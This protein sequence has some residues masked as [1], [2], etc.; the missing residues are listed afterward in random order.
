MPLAGQ[1]FFGNLPCDG[2]AQDRIST[3][4]N[5]YEAVFPTPLGDS[6]VTQF[7]ERQGSISQ[8]QEFIQR[9]KRFTTPQR[10]SILQ[11]TWETRTLRSTGS[12]QF[13][14]TVAFSLE[15]VPHHM[16]GTWRSSKK[17][18]QR[19]AA[20]RALGLLV[21]RWGEHLTVG[22]TDARKAMSEKAEGSIDNGMNEAQRL[23]KISNDLAGNL[24]TP[25]GTIAAAPVWVVQ[26]EANGHRAC[27][28]LYVLGVQHT[29]SGAVKDTPEAAC[30]DTAR[31]VLW[32]LQCPDFEDAFDVNPAAEQHMLQAPPATIWTKESFGE[33][34]SHPGDHEIIERTRQ[35]LQCMFGS[36]LGPGE[37][38]WEW[39]FENMDCPSRPTC[40]RASVQVQG[41]D[42]DFHGPWRHCQQR[43]LV[44]A[45]QNLNRFLDEK[46]FSSPSA[47]SMKMQEMR[48]PIHD[49][50]CGG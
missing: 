5:S 6:K 25:G 49:E 50:I 22:Y 44:A 24:G 3:K 39:R 33:Q 29:F 15:G 14:A 47:S 8:L 41:L 9:S 16:S 28:E 30:N 7:S 4:E 32:Y 21:G 36:A 38:V 42:R 43:A 12:H 13:S 11:W 37:H 45:C 10:S 40:F 46:E 27:V 17:L 23:E 19:D 35:R 20:D 34:D 1:V 2:S 31:R 26:P 18:A 48:Y